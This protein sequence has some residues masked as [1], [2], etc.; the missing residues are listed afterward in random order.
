M[1]G[2]PR[3]DKTMNETSV[4]NMNRHRQCPHRTLQPDLMKRID[5]DKQ[6]RYLQMVR[7]KAMSEKEKSR[8][9]EECGNKMALLVISGQSVSVILPRKSSRE[10]PSVA[11][12]FGG[13]QHAF[14]LLFLLG[15]CA[16]T[17]QSQS[18]SASSTP[19]LSR[20]SSSYR[21]SAWFLP[22]FLCIAQLGMSLGV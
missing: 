1:K 2:N 21:Y 5:H 12:H 14:I 20:T 18:T 7:V 10:P 19:L 3:L 15:A 6:G 16:L 13:L 4:A 22:G 17:F 9:S 11:P 8:S